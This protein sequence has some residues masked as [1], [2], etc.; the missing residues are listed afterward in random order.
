MW[1]QQLLHLGYV[2]LLESVIGRKAKKQEKGRSFQ[3]YD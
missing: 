2:S 1:M 3:I